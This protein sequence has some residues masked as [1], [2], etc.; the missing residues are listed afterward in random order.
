M[1]KTNHVRI[2][3]KSLA[4]VEI[5]NDWV[6]NETIVNVYHNNTHERHRICNEV[7]QKEFELFLIKNY[8]RKI[9]RSEIEKMFERYEVE[10]IDAGVWNKLLQYYPEF[11]PQKFTE[12]TQHT[13]ERD[14]KAF[15]KGSREFIKYLNSLKPIK[16]EWVD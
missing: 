9:S 6:T 13:T 15:F 7:G 10:A 16:L 11:N 2:S 14:V 3:S 4:F 5:A 12:M 8:G 1:D